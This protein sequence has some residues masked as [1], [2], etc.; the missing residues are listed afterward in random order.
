M[1]QTIYEIVTNKI[2]ESL[3]KG[4]APWCKPWTG[5]VPQNYVTGHEYRGINTVITRASLICD[6]YKDPRFL[7]YKQCEALGGKVK[8]GSKA[9][10]I[11]FWKM[12][13]KEVENKK[14]GKKETEV[15]MFAS[16]YSVF[17]VEQCELPD[18]KP[19]K[20]N[21]SRAI[22]PIAEAAALVDAY[23][24][25]EGL[26]IEHSSVIGACYSPAKDTVYMPHMEQ[27]VSSEA[28]YST[29]FHEL[30]HSTGNPKRLDRDIKNLFGS[31]KYS[32]EELVA[33][34]G[35]AMTMASLGLN[36]DIEQSASYCQSW[37]NALQN[38]RKM[39]VFASQQASK[40]CALIL[41]DA[42]EELQE[43]A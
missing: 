13:K 36:H 34:L 27:F 22:D 17:N 9:L 7:T 15:G 19:L 33:E 3:D 25:R 8:K 31:H 12:F 6:G 1:K 18:L 16:Y 11:V 24:T 21:E 35:A 39:I 32:K 2:I 26:G 38:D 43:A 28:Y 20:T 23:A 29:M 30:T 42:Q 4:V 40:A 5:S 37:L 14:T 10:P 41:G